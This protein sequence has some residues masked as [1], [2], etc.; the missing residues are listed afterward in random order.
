MTVKNPDEVS[1]SIFRNFTD[2]SGLLVPADET[3]ILK[4]EGELL[5]EPKDITSTSDMLVSTF[6]RLCVIE[7]ITVKFFTE[8]FK[9]YAILKLGRTPQSA[10]NNKTNAIK[11]LKH[12]DKISWKKFTE[13]TE[14]LGYR[15]INITV[16]F[17]K[18]NNE[19]IK[20]STTTSLTDD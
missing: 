14:V 15:P 13:L 4:E 7:H 2:M 9:R 3:E 5:F 19:E 12:E 8:M 20:V 16:T 11:M 6:C 1:S 10:S 18:I 17:A